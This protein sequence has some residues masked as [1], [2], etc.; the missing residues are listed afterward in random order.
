MISLLSSLLGFAGGFTPK[1]LDFFQARQNMKHELLL[2]E[3]KIKMAKELSALKIKE[4]TVKSMTEQ[5][6]LFINMTN[7]F[8]KLIHQNLL[9]PYQQVLDLLLHI[10]CL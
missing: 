7:N 9:L 5:Q 4:E 2:Q 3:N 6:K 1:L 10:V 8:P